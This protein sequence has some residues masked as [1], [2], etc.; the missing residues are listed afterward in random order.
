ME[1]LDAIRERILF[2]ANDKA[3]DI[4]YA[5]QKQIGRITD[6]AG[7]KA[8]EIQL[9][10]EESS[11]KECGNI[12]KRANSLAV[13]ER[14]KIILSA[15]QNLVENVLSK[16]LDAVSDMPEKEKIKLYVEML[17]KVCT[18]DSNETVT[19]NVKD[20][21]LADEVLKNVSRS[22]KISDN[23]GN[24]AGG[25]IIQNGNIELNM[26]FDMVVQHYKSQLVS[27]AAKTLF[28]QD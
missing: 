25:F 6:E 2:I 11:K 1:G 14:R 18:G 27:I 28:D 22:V 8:K 26:T 12:L 24:F 4:D 9:K 13:S 10:F 16:A 19:F 21:E 15:R 3:S 5:A 20:K 17:E 7:K 23:C